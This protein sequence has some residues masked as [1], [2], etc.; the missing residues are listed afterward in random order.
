[1]KPKVFYL[2]R[3]ALTA[4]L[5]LNISSQPPLHAESLAT[6]SIAKDLERALNKK[7]ISTLEAIAPQEDQLDLASRYKVLLAIFPNARWKIKEVNPLKNGKNALRVSLTGDK[8]IKGEKYTLEAIQLIGVRT[9]GN[10][11]IEQEVLEEQAIIQNSEP[12]LPISINVPSAVLTGT[13]YDFDIVLNK[14]LGDTMIIG[15]LIPIT[16]EQI[17]SQISPPIELEPL[18][19]GG[20]F[21]SVKAPLKAGVQNWAAVIVHPEGL[22]SITKRVRIVE[23]ESEIKL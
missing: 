15:G 23:V 18:G 17:K 1:M 14:P 9:F 10:K 19:G 16:T 13:T 21:K 7:D 3:V 22:I 6:Q 5:L 4:S 20:L 2:L 11:I 12:P 8:T